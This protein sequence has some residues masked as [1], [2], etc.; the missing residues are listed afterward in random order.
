MGSRTNFAWLDFCWNFWNLDHSWNTRKKNSLKK[1]APKHVHNTFAHFWERFWEFSE[2]WIFLDFLKIFEN[3]TLHGTLG[4]FF[5]SKKSPQN[6]FKTCLDTSGNNF[7]S[8]WIFEN[9][10]IFLKVFSKSLPHI[11]NP[12][13]WTY[14]LSSGIWT[15]NFKSGKLN[16]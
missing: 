10:L 6:M 13:M 4:K 9:F 2:L 14:I 15:H 16:S 7:G 12:E 8:F 3:S 5:F 1:I 11:L